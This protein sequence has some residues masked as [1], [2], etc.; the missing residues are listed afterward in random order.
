MKRTSLVFKGGVIGP[1]LLLMFACAGQNGRDATKVPEEEN[2]G[3]NA[4]SQADIVFDTLSCDFGTIIEGEMV[5]S[6]A[7][8]PRLSLTIKANVTNNK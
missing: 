2:M 4:S 7:L 1:T 5:V 3:H 6:N 8:T